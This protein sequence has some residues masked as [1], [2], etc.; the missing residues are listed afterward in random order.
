MIYDTIFNIIASMKRGGK[1][2]GSG[3]KAIE[4]R[5]VKVKLTY[6]TLET[7]DHI[8]VGDTLSEKIR[9]SIHTGIRASLNNYGV[10]YTPSFLS[11]FVVWLC[12]RYLKPVGELKAFDPACGECSLLESL[13]K[14]CHQ[15]NV[16]VSLF[17]DDVDPH[18]RV[19]AEN[20]GIRFFNLDALFPKVGI[21]SQNFWKKTLG[22][23]NLIIEN[24]PWSG[25]K[26]YSKEELSK[27]GY[28]LGEGQYDVFSLFIEL[29]L[30]IAKEGTFCGFIVPDS[31]FTSED[32]STRRFLL[33]N[34]NILAIARLGEKLFPS[35]HRATA[36]IVCQKGKRKETGTECFRLLPKD[37]NLVLSGK[38]ALSDLFEEKRYTIPQSR[39]I[40]DGFSFDIDTSENE[41]SLTGHIRSQAKSIS[42]HF[43]FGRGVEISKKGNQTKCPNC[44][45]VQAYSRYK[46]E[47]ICSECGQTFNPKE[48]VYEV[49]S[50]KPKDG[51]VPIYV[52]ESVQRYSL[53]GRRF[54]LPDVPGINYKTP[55]LYAGR[56]ILVR[57]TGLGLKAV[58]EENGL[59]TQTVY[60]LSPK[61]PAEDIFYYL[62]IFNSRVVYFSYL[63]SSGENEW[64][65]HPYITKKMVYSLPIKSREDVSSEDAKAISD[66]AQSLVKR[67]SYKTDLALEQIIYKIYGLS[68]AEIQTIE[69][70]INSLPD[71]GAINGM[72]TNLE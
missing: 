50:V 31:I 53:R 51:F 69:K 38:K 41:A 64:K 17:G 48:N 33:E 27:G 70:T 20:E 3:R 12:W 26:V 42:E 19:V 39:F 15:S 43:V 67:Y 46:D 59:F 10:V 62:G 28:E 36:V 57:K 14:L 45:T 37:K 56:K 71:L 2:L 30:A 5:E 25:D 8:Y 60:S 47:K 40:E 66:M 18:Y 55:G 24:P 35:V 7:I 63:K 29:S 34:S 23:V 4:G 6:E 1:R 52:G 65:S 72:K 11:D 16:D 21:S 54:I 9:E 49:I 13:A 68:K 44:G 58:T 32:S 22:N 61:D